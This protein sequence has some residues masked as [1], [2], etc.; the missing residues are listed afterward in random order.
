[1]PVN[2]NKAVRR[3]IAKLFVMTILMLAVGVGLREAALRKQHQVLLTVS[4][5]P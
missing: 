2:I 5:R 1:M 4:K 3:Y